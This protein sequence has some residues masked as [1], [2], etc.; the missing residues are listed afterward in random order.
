[1]SDEFVPDKSDDAFVPDEP[2][3]TRAQRAT[4]NDDTPGDE[5]LK[6]PAQLRT[7]T[8]SPDLVGQF[9][10]MGAE[11]DARRNPVMSAV[12]VLGN[13]ATFGAG[14]AISAAISHPTLGPEYDQ[15][16]A[17]NQAQLESDRKSVGGLGTAALE[18]VGGLAPAMLAPEL[19][20]VNALSPVARGVAAGAGFGAA[21]GA[22][23]SLS[24][25]DTANIGRNAA[26][27]AVAGGAT[28]GL[29]E[30]GMNRLGSHAGAQDEWLVH[31]ILGGD[32]KT[33]ANP[34]ERKVLADDAADLQHTLANDPSLR[35]QISKAR[36]G[37][38]AELSKLLDATQGR[39]QAVIAP[40]DEHYANF[41]EESPQGGYRVGDMVDSVENRLKDFQRT[42]GAKERAALENVRDSLKKFEGNDHL[43]DPNSPQAKQ[44]ANANGITI[45]KVIGLKQ[46]Q[47]AE[48][49]SPRTIK[50]QHPD[51]FPEDGHFY[52]GT[53]RLNALRNDTSLATSH[54][55]STPYLEGRNGF[56]HHVD[57]EG[58]NIADAGDTE[59]AAKSIGYEPDNR[60]GS[61]AYHYELADSKKVQREL[62]N[63]GF[64]A[65]SYEDVGPENRYTHDTVRLINPNVGKITH[66]RSVDTNGNLVSQGRIEA[67]TIPPDESNIRSIQDEINN[68]TSQYG[69]PTYNPDKII[70]TSQARQVLTDLQ[71]DVH[72]ALGGYNERDAYKRARL[73]VKPIQDAFEAHLNTGDPE[74]VAQI[75]DMNRRYSALKNVESVVKQRLNKSTQQNLAVQRAPSSIRAMARNVGGVGGGALITATGHPVLGA[76][77]VASGAAPEIARGADMALSRLISA[78]K[79]PGYKGDI[80]G[81]VK[82]AITKGVPRSVAMQF[83]G[84]AVGGDIHG[85]L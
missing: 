56:I 6:T 2:P 63:R 70:P 15:A 10:Q 59:E 74:A 57:I 11:L 17:A 81:L 39:L 4:E 76:A 65:L 47:L 16:R 54:G 37:D 31:D 33:Q 9:K 43:I 69:V 77:M 73:V 80:A 32:A 26:I 29:F 53:Q 35:R 58:A 49:M 7:F 79:T 34:T 22:G 30:G 23:E 28:G 52:S 8:P 25:G 42:G 72:D 67:R 13:A 12:N 24:R 71:G 46:K 50:V 61:P 38:P 85:A 84:S 45:D 20:G 5:D 64:D 40:R 62:I 1:M 14:P 75:R 18:T 48:A 27:G 83:A 51:D 78:S 66:V 44:F 3:K 60:P 36:G 41:D 21:Q 55:E 19:E 68:I 82:D